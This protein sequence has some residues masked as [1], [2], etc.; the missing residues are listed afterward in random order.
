MAIRT[1]L[2]MK[3]LISGVIILMIAWCVDLLH[4][5]PRGRGDNQDDSRSGKVDQS[6]DGNSGQGDDK[7]AGKNVRNPKKGGAQGDGKGPETLATP[8]GEGTS[9]AEGDGRRREQAANCSREGL[10]KKAK[11]QRGLPPGLQKKY[12][13]GGVD[14]LPGPWQERVRMGEVDP[15]SG[16]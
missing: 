5:K 7:K 16:R 13:Q 12:D 1:S 4:A 14:A 2:F 9:A 6:G 3:V 10:P 8:V 11:K 15:Q